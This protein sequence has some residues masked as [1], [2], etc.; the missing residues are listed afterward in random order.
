MSTPDLFWMGFWQFNYTNDGY[1][2][3][4]AALPLINVIL[5]HGLVALAGVFVFLAVRFVMYLKRAGT[6]RIATLSIIISAVALALAIFGN[7]P[8]MVG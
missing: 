8:R 2:A 7:L 6:A 1:T 3:E 5:P 4:Q